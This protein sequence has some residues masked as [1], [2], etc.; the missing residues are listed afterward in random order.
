MCALVP[1]THAAPLVETIAAL[2][3]IHPL[4]EVDLPPVVDDFHPKIDLVMDRKAF[5]C[6]LTRFPC[7]SFDDLLSTVYELLQDCFV[8]DGSISSFDLLYEI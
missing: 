3:Y 1:N 8:Y 5:I 4:V 2:R 7:L 6:A